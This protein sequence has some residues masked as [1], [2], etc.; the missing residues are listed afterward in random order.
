M[1]IVT[2]HMP[3][4]T[5]IVVTKGR[6][7]ELEGLIVALRRQTLRPARVLIVGT[8]ADDIEIDVDLAKDLFPCMAWVANRL[9]TTCQRN[10]G[11]AFLRS[12]NVLCANSIVIFFD[13]DFRPNETWIS[14]CAALFA[15]K[16]DVGGMTGRI[17]ADGVRSGGLSEAEGAAFL[18][19]TVPAQKHWATGVQ[20]DISCMYG[21]NM[22]FRATTLLACR[23]DEA[24]PLYGWQE[25]RDITGQV[26]RLTRAILH[27][28]CQ[29][30]HLGSR[31]GRSSGL[32][33]GYA[34]I[35]NIVYLR[36]KGTA[37]TQN[38]IRHLARAFVGNF[39]KMLRSSDRPMY[40]ERL[41]GNL[42]AV[43]HIIAGRC[44]P[45]HISRLP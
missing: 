9:G 1:S 34:Q 7:R 30:V 44:E 3:D 18:S 24:L 45:Q 11:V 6:P 41:R 39:V 14:E 8:C 38:A 42:L 17:L 37:D 33:F 2:P 19:G 40:G 36:R 28:A 29:G 25:D 5:I 35:A 32:R 16:P 23:F 15:S 43:S 12:L 27:P 31:G 4:V 13:D 26:R 10:S 22:A 21:C 20:R